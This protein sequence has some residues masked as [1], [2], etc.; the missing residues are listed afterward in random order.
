MENISKLLT[1]IF[2]MKFDV[3]IPVSGCLIAVLIGFIL[4][5]V[6]YVSF[7]AKR[8]KYRHQPRVH[9]DFHSVGFGEEDL[10]AAAATAA[11]T[12]AG[13]AAVQDEAAP[14]DETA[15]EEAPASTEA[16]VSAPA[17][18]PEREETVL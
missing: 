15:P 18:N 3:V 6:R 2:D 5:L 7:Q 13:K 1:D 9:R 16:P 10:A 17:E 11:V 8:R 12:A 4:F 14:E